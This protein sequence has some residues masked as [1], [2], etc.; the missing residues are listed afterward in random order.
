MRP[1]GRVERLRCP[2]HFQ[3]RITEAGGRNRY[4]DPMFKL[5]WA[6]TATMRQGG[7]WNNEDGY[8]VGYRDVYLG[9]GLP[10]WMLLQWADAGKSIELPFLPA[11]SDQGWYAE[12]QCPK[13]GLQILGGYPYHGRY[14]IAM[15]L[16]AKWFDGG[17]LHIHPYPLDAEIVNMMVPVIKA[18]LKVSLEAKLR[19]MRECRE[20]DDAEYAKAVD[21]VWHG[22]RRKSTLAATSWLE[23]KQRAIER[24][25]NAAVLTRMARGGK[26][27]Q[28]EN[29]I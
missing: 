19:F 27:F 16:V 20:Q 21:D 22:I 18:S 13:T 12:N 1:S 2:E 7:E 11:Q 17:H 15:N 4:G 6:Q 5:A 14:Q 3:E 10:H 29:R 25:F 23:D 28:S 24:N 8:F 26:F 9:D